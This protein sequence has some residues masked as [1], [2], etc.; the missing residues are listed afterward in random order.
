MA[1]FNTS[2]LLAAQT[3]LK[4]KYAK[5][6]MRMKPVPAL[7]LLLQNTDFL[8]VDAK[9]LRTRED[10]PIEAHL[11]TRTKRATGT[12]RTHNHTGSIDDSMKVTLQ[13]LT[14]TDK[15]AMTLKLLDNNLFEYNTVLANKLEQCMMN[16]LEDYETA[17]I[18]YL[19]A[20]RTQYSASLK[21]ATFNAATDVVEI[22]ADKK[23]RF[24]QMLKSVMRQNKY[25]NQLDVIADSLMYVDGEFIAA[26]GAGN[27]TNYGFQFNGLNIVESIELA[28][29][30]YPAGTVLAMPKQS[31][32]ALNWI[33]K[34]NRVGWGDYN[35]N[36]G[37]YGTIY[38]PW[39]N[40]P[41]AIHGYAERA[42]KS[43]VNGDTQDVALEFEVSLDLSFNKAPLSGANSESVIYEAAMVS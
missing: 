32:A 43:A 3:I 16:I 27:S 33:P 13:W 29:A 19:L 38:D 23:E 5:Q 28:D 18:A 24:Y 39:F 7:G 34:Q 11:L 10:R 25:G 37:G 12:Q 2:N 20:N 17:G 42:D 9:T 6:E 4:Q 41:F 26:Q 30:N 21:G 15:T 31:V 40:L 8:T 14:K 36:V 22:T 1:N 35:S